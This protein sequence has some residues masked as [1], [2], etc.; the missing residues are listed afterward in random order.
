MGPLLGLV[1]CCLGENVIVICKIVSLQC[2]L[3]TFILKKVIV[4]I[5]EIL[6][7][8][9]I[10][11]KKRKKKGIL[12]LLFTFFSSPGKD[13]KII[14]VH[15][16]LT[17]IHMF[18]LPYWLSLFALAILQKLWIYHIWFFFGASPGVDSYL[19]HIRATNNNK[20]VSRIYVGMS[21]TNMYLH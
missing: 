17:K 19:Y 7:C 21:T 4:L 13:T 3:D 12:D 8:C 14:S 2:R 1:C 20:M 5:L 6:N 9:L 10:K 18:C 15:I 16:S 11:K